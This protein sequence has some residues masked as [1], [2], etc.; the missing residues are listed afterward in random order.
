MEQ[1]CL[2]NCQTSFFDRWNFSTLSNKV[3]IENKTVVD[4]FKKSRYFTHVSHNLIN[5]LKDYFEHI[6]YEENALI[7]EQ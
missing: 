5:E 2:W 4:F 3:F 1:V 7:L 6:L